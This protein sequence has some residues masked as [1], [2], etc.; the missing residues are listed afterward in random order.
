MEERDGIGGEGR[1]RGGEREGEGEG[2]RE[3][4]IWG[5]RSGEEVEKVRVREIWEKGLGRDGKGGERMRKRWERGMKVDKG[6]GRKRE[7]WRGRREA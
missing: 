5:K 1:G 4:G 7:R 3:L 2:E 6:T